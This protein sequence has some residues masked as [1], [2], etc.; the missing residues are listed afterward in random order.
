MKRIIL[1]NLFFLI[2][3]CAIKIDKNYIYILF[4]KRRNIKLQ[5]NKKRKKIS[6]NYVV[7]R[8]VE[9]ILKCMSL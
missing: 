1:V 4:L 5:I 8:F 7:L 6:W 3:S 9:I 2:S